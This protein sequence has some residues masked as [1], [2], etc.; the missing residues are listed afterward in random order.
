[1]QSIIYFCILVVEEKELPVVIE[2]P[3][4]WP[5]GVVEQRLQDEWDDDSDFEMDFEAMDFL[6]IGELAFLI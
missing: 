5:P 4:Q 1:M 6:V 3:I 2:Q